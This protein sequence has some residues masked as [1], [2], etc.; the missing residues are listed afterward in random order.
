MES[1]IKKRNS[2]GFFK[3]TKNTNPRLLYFE[4]FSERKVATKYEKDLKLLNS[5]NPFQILNPFIKY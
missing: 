1:S 5:K 4:K 3:S 2:L